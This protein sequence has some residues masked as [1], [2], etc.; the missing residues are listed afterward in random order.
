M[1]VSAVAL[2]SAVTVALA[3]AVTVALASAAFAAL[4]S[5]QADMVRTLNHL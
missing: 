2:A 5:V 4:V 3:S 1:K